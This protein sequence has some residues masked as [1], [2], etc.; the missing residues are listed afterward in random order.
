LA[1]GSMAACPMLQIKNTFLD[2]LDAPARHM[3]KMRTCPPTLLAAIERL[4]VE[5]QER[6]SCSLSEAST[7][8]FEAWSSEATSSDDEF[9]VKTPSERS[10]EVARWSR[11]LALSEAFAAST[12][13]DDSV[14]E[15]FCDTPSERSFP[16]GGVI[17]FS[18]AEPEVQSSETQSLPEHPGAVLSTGSLLHAEGGCRPCAWFWKPGGCTQREAC[19]YCHLC[20]Q[21]ALE[22]HAAARRRART[23]KRQ[24]ERNQ[25]RRRAPARRSACLV[26]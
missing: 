17:S 11:P 8:A 5:A 26:A 7:E 24:Q 12:G 18:F 1:S 4:Q 3:R 19:T 2:T 22:E 23:L 25:V 9:V 6:T 21:G 13:V 16:Q 15:A 20:P 14:E 10:Y